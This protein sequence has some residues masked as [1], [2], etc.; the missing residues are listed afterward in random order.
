MIVPYEV[1]N[2]ISFQ[3]VVALVAHIKTVNLQHLET[4][5]L[6]TKFLIRSEYLTDF[7][8]VGFS[9][10]SLFHSKITE[11]QAEAMGH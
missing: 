11:E 7:I 9:L 3:E 2:I 5:H 4:D 10:G 8:D 6:H 1:G